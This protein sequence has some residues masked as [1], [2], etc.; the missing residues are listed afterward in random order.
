MRLK[1]YI[2]ENYSDFDE[3]RSMV[4]K[5]CQPYIKELK[6]G[7]DLLWR[8]SR[9]RINHIERIKSR[10]N[11]RR[12]T[13][14]PREVHD[15]MNDLFKKRFGWYVRNGIFATGKYSE[16]RNYGLGYIFFPIGKYEYVWS[17]ETKD[18]FTETKDSPYMF[19]HGEPYEQLHY[20][21][22][23]E[24][25]DDKVGHWEYD[26]QP[27]DSSDPD[28]I[29]DQLGL[30][31]MEYDEFELDW[32]P[33]IT[34]NEYSD[35]KNEE[36]EK[37]REDYFQDLADY[38]TNKGLYRAIKSNNEIMF[39]CKEYYLIHEKHAMSIR[40]VLEGRYTGP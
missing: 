37:K 33:E 39:N 20:E 3:V 24:Y 34:Y 4:Q 14:T 25:G 36:W 13:D 11:N 12:P 18:F 8:G 7:S 19:D 1:S 26:G 17:P 31:E 29:I 15:Y 22:E 23:N 16:T 6:G 32:I 27:V 40:E 2:N 30:E 10:L 5:N 21:W 35:K 38:Y 9:K 28:E